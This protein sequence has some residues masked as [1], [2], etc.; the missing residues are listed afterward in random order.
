LKLLYNEKVSV[1]IDLFLGILLNIVIFFILL[2]E[3]DNDGLKPSFEIDFKSS[4]TS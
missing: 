4:F 2:K 1:I 3:E